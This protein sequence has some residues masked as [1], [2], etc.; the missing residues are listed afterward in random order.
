MK[1]YT[2]EHKT[3]FIFYYLQYHSLK[4]HIYITLFHCKF[5]EVLK[6]VR[7]FKFQ[8]SP[9]FFIFKTDVIKQ[10]TFA[11]LLAMFIDFQC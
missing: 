9:Y 5:Y 11:F 4:I 7:H 10:K 2:F 6:T 8:F 1:H 3:Q